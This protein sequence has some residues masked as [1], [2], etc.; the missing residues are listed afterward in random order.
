QLPD[1]LGQE[2]SYGK[3]ILFSKEDPQIMNK[4]IVWS[5]IVVAVLLLPCLIWSS[6]Q[7]A[8][9]QEP[10]EVRQSPAEV[11]AEAG[12]LSP[13]GRHKL[14]LEDRGLARELTAK[15]GR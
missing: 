3:D 9:S 1:G 14:R 11:T 13:G 10:V 2:H 8:A 5:L 4:R 15:G 7:Q 6:P 12:Y